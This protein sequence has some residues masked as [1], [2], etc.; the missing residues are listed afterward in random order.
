M[1]LVA[2][3]KARYKKFTNREFVLRFRNGQL[4]NQ[5]YGGG[6]FLLPLIDE[7]IVLTTTIQNLEIDVAEKI[8]TSENQD[9]RVNGFVVWRIEDPVKAYQ[10][11]SGSQGVGVMTEINRTLQQLV[12]SIIR[13]TVARLTLDQV[14]RERS[15][16]IEAIMMELIQVVGPMGI[17]INTTEIR[18]VEVVDD[19]L[20]HDLQETYRQEARLTAEQ[21]KIQTQKEIDKTQALSMQQVRLFQAEQDELAGTREL[22]RD[23]NILLEQQ[24]LNETEQ[25]RLKSIQELEKERETTVAQLD[26]QKQKI[27]ANTRLIQVEIEAESKKRRQILEQI[28]VEAQKKKLMAEADAEAIRITATAERDAAEL[29]KQ[30]MKAEAEGK[31]SILFAEAEG[32]REKVKAQG[33]V[34]EAMIMY[35]LMQ[36]MPEIAS[37]MKVGDV[38]WLNLGG[39]A[40]NGDSPLGII[41]K[42]IVQLLG[43]SKSF[44]LDVGNLMGSIRSKDPQRIIQ[45][46]SSADETTEFIPVEY[47]SDMLSNATAVYENGEIVGFDTDG[48]GDVDFRIPTG[49]HVVLDKK[50]RIKG[51]DLDGDGESDFNLPKD[52]IAYDRDGDGT[53]DALDLDGDGH[54]DINLMDLLAVST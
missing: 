38:N 46:Q 11:I 8:I 28:E 14:L 22:E 18:H 48:D 43:I 20:F 7:L 35:E 52:M 31:K 34:N 19:S 40:E 29:R 6:Y 3:I 9:V 25:R 4:K 15:L 41:P 30:G 36:K 44:G 2:V 5:G 47:T 27:E 54:P 13:T 42:N 33:L 50:G 32:L 17:Q 39:S 37:A 26:Q 24:K 1:A 51:F 16:I 21:V 23:R 10:S 12:E 53:I 45:A 49:I